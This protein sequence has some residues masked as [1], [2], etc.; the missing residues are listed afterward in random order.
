MR[1]QSSGLSMGDR[2]RPH[3]RLQTETFASHMFVRRVIRSSGFA[4]VHL[5]LPHARLTLH[6]AAPAHLAVAGQAG[7][8]HGR[9]VAPPAA[10]APAAG[11]FGARA[12]ARARGVAGGPA[13]A[14]GVLQ[15]DQVGDAQAL[16]VTARPRQLRLP[17]G[18]VGDA[19]HPHCGV[20]AVLEQAARVVEGRQLLPASPY[21]ARAGD[22][23]TLARRFQTA[24]HRLRWKRQRKEKK[25][26]RREEREEKKKGGMSVPS[27]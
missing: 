12:A 26:H 11:V 25:K 1:D 20:V 18:G 8:A 14:G 7:E 10:Q 21:G 16:A 4:G 5:F 23:V 22:A 2:P 3:A 13:E 15:E 6:V 24:L 27:V 9:V 17:R 19:Q